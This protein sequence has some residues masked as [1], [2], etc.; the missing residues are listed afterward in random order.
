MQQ[1]LE[2]LHVMNGSDRGE[3]EAPV[4]SG[5]EKEVSVNGVSIS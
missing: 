5:P 2:M 4:G 1:Y 3:G